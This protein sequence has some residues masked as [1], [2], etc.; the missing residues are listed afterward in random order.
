MY[1][2]SL[3]PYDMKAACKAAFKVALKAAFKV[4]FKSR[5]LSGPRQKTVKVGKPVKLNEKTV[6]V[7]KALLNK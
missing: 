2:F 1:R 6:K 7:Q 4:A 5:L 3:S